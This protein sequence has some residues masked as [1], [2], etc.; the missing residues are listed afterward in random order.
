M[1]ERG[2]SAIHA[3]RARRRPPTPPPLGSIRRTRAAS[4]ADAR[5]DFVLAARGR[6]PRSPRARASRLDGLS[7]SVARARRRR[8]PLPRAAAAP[9]AAQ[10]AARLTTRAVEL[11]A[12]RHRRRRPPSA[13]PS[14]LPEIAARA[15]LRR[16]PPTRRAWRR[17]RSSASASSKRVRG[18]GARELFKFHLRRESRLTRRARPS[19]ASRATSVARVGA[20]PPS[21]RPSPGRA[22]ALTAARSAWSRRGDVESSPSSSS[23]SSPFSRAASPS[24]ARRRASRTRS[25][26]E[27]QFISAGLVASASRSV[28]ASAMCAASRFLAVRG[29]M[30]LQV[31]DARHRAERRRRARRRRRRLPRRASAVAL[32]PRAACASTAA[33]TPA[34]TRAGLFSAK[35]RR[36]FQSSARASA[37]SAD[38]FPSRACPDSSR[39][40][41]AFLSFE[42]SRDVRADCV[43]SPTP[44]RQPAPS[45]PRR[46]RAETLRPA[47]AAASSSEL[48]AAPQPSPL[49]FL[50]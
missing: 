48:G 33:A 4:A 39:K 19:A 42:L 14:R 44:P 6:A 15:A 34:A 20:R 8:A 36:R 2:G 21:A 10:A 24:S 31:L 17:S 13:P 38:G 12:R 25:F 3:Q 26:R 16:S 47:A 7:T 30:R 9:P 23:S 45:S 32:E 28:R 40:A 41:S 22:S 46:H 37:I 29:D 1:N 18:F 11:R 27:F 50:L 49:S 5:S 35:P 43:A